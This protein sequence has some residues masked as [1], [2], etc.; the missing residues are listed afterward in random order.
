MANYSTIPHAA[1][2]DGSTPPAHATPWRRL[3]ASALVVSFALGVIG[4]VAGAP[5]TPDAVPDAF[6]VREPREVRPRTG[7]GA[8]RAAR[9]GA[10]RS[11]QTKIEPRGGAHYTEARGGAGV[12]GLSV[13]IIIPVLR[14]TF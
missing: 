4:A 10:C 13:A 9:G 5:L 14:S 8:P 6:A 2:D 1:V 7:R 3:V 12:R 11:D